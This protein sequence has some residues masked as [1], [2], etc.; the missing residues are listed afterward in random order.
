M[1]FL[2]KTKNYFYLHFFLYFKEPLIKTRNYFYLHFYKCFNESILKKKN[3]LFDD[4][5]IFF[6]YYFNLIII[7]KI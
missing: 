6:D 7:L 3:Y 1:D 4:Y 5:P 2:F